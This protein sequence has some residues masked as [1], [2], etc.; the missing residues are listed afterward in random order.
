[1]QCPALL[2]PP[3]PRHLSQAQNL[4]ATEYALHPYSHDLPPRRADTG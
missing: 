2:H 4:K 3:V 1:M